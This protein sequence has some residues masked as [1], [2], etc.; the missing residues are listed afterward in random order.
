MKGIFPLPVSEIEK[1]F[2][3][4]RIPL[5]V[6]S[7]SEYTLAQFMNEIVKQEEKLVAVELENPKAVIEIVRELGL[8]DKENINYILALKRI[9]GIAE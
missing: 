1:I 9:A 5:P 3:S 8:T 2:K 4:F 7:Q 6:L